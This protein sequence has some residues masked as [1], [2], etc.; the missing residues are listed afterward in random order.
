MYVSKYVCMYN[1]VIHNNI[2][3]KSSCI[4]NKHYTKSELSTATAVLFRLRLHKKI[5]DYIQTGRGKDLTCELQWIRGG[6]T[7]DNG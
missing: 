7:Q 6:L 5:I 3:C 2:R 1:R 4:I